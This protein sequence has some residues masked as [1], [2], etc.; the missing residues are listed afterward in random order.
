MNTD[1]LQFYRELLHFLQH[2]KKMSLRKITRI[3]E[4]KQKAKPSISGR[5]TAR[6]IQSLKKGKNHSKQKV[7]WQRLQ[8]ALRIDSDAFKEAFIRSSYG[9]LEVLRYG[10]LHSS[11]SFLPTVYF[12]A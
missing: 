3:M 6:T 12:V 9:I 1:K 11:G 2:S 5:F 7:L 4:L 10:S 8:D